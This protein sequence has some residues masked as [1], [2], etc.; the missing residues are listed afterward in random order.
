MSASGILFGRILNERKG[1]ALES[2]A[3]TSL[4]L[5]ECSVPRV[6]CFRLALLQES[7][8]WRWMEGIWE[9]WS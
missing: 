7:S 1:F 3:K 4:L 2:A 9:C 6:L 8:A 5:F